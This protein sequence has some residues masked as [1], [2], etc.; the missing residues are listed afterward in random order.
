MDN[1]DNSP[2]FLASRT[3]DS[4]PMLLFVMN[5]PL[6]F[7]AHKLRHSSPKKR[8]TAQEHFAASRP[9]APLTGYVQYDMIS[10]LKEGYSVKNR[11]K[12]VLIILIVSALLMIAGVSLLFSQLWA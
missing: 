11:E 5:M 2:V 9:Y 3:V 6:P 1:V 7:S 12:T 4:F 10:L 8:Q